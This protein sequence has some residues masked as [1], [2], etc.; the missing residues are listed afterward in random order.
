MKMERRTF[1]FLLEERI[2][3]DIS[4]KKII[5]YSFDESDFPMFIKVVSLNDTQARL[6]KFLL[7]NRKDEVINRTDIL[8]YV[9][10]SFNLSSSNQ[11]LWQSMNSLRRKLCSIGLPED[12]ITN[13]HGV[14]YSVDNTRILSL[15]VN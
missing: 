1:G 3:F 8:H 4:N 9:W 12:F 13:V 6:L 5:H 14:G 15:L 7:V 11:R 10:D 2:L